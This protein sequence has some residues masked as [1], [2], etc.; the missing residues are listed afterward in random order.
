[1]E[2]RIMNAKRLVTLILAV[3]I[4]VT[5]GILSASAIEE[6][7]AYTPCCSRFAG[8]AERILDYFKS[9][10]DCT[11]TVQTYCPKCGKIFDTWTG[12]YCP[13]PHNH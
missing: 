12:I 11:S 9:G 2:E 13:C 8:R 1:M 10:E 7:A 5:C 6:T 4:I 3:I